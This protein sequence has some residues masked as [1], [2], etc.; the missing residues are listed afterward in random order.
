MWKFASRTAAPVERQ[1][2]SERKRTAESLTEFPG[3]NVREKDFNT[4]LR[5]VLFE[6]K[7][8]ARMGAALWLYGWLVLRQTHQQ[9]GE[10]W[11][12]GGAPVS[13]REIEEETGF[14]R[15]TLEHWMRT[16][17]KHG[18]IQTEAAP[19][20]VVIRIT[21]AKKFKKFQSFAQS[22]RNGTG[23]VRKVA[24]ASPQSCVGNAVDSHCFQ[25]AAERIGSSS[26]V[27]SKENPAKIHRD[28]HSG[29]KERQTDRSAYTQSNGQSASKNNYQNSSCLGQQQNQI[30]NQN[31]N[32]RNN[33]DCE[34]PPATPYTQRQFWIEARMRLQL[35]RA[36]NEEAV[37]RE[38]MVGGG[39]EII[40]S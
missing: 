28:F 5:G 30:Q 34:N 29:G 36:E 15:R 25:Q 23:G 13:Y 40:R 3:E 12:L 14:N 26:V 20:G 22:V 1:G 33:R 37:R 8:Y 10:G 18:Y 24:E 38:L 16:L 6:E 11:V 7:H 19:S 2:N 4:G 27:G 31:C 9:G 21:K 39:P 35:L 32:S 17:R